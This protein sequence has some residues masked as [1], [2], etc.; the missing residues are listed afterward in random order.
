MSGREIPGFYWD[1]EKRKYFRIQANHVAPTGSKY[2]K[3]AVTQQK[4]DVEQQRRRANIERRI[5]KER[6]KRSRSLRH[7]INGITTEVCDKPTPGFVLRSYRGEIFASQLQPRQLCNFNDIV[8]GGTVA[9]FTRHEETGA[10]ILGIDRGNSCTIL[11]CPPSSKKQETYVY[12]PS[13]DAAQIYLGDWRLASL[14]LCASGH[15]LGI[16]NS[17]GG[18]G[19]IYVGSGNVNE[20]ATIGGS[21]W[22]NQRTIIDNVEDD[23]YV[24][25]SA[26]N[27]SS[28]SGTLAVGTS[29][30]LRTFDMNTGNPPSVKKWDISL[31]GGRQKSK[32]PAMDLL[33]VDWL[34]PTVIASG[35]RNSVLCLSDLRSG[36]HSKRIRHPCSIEQVKKVD[37]HRVVLAG[38]RSMC[39][40]DLRF[41]KFPTKE[42]S[43]NGRVN[44]I[45]S[46]PYLVF[47]NYDC[48]IAPKID[49][50]WELGMVASTTRD[51]SIKF[52]SLA[53]GSVLP[54]PASHPASRY[55]SVP[56][57]IS[58]LLFENP[59]YATRDWQRPRLL[60]ARGN[61]IQEWTW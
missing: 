35:F 59:Q 21:S 47:E 58:R 15:F 54:S 37:D 18:G 48:E 56:G 29:D 10:L 33:A 32:R 51:Q 5:Q 50:S 25:C 13:K 39:M 38:Y 17:T 16:M 31:F 22:R 24:W 40:Y 34:S 43:N 30:G 6:V 60:V 9:D 11:V 3:E 53:D 55:P 20:M 7:T 61:I 14:S 26:A 1:T 41:T 57:N 49:L 2:S 36:G 8:Q 44:G 27:P 4:Y 46:E 45:S 28:G 12:N 23:F 42:T 19:G 52:H